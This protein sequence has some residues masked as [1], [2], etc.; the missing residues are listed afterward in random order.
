M[1]EN[2]SLTWI[3]GGKNIPNNLNM[4]VKMDNEDISVVTRHYTLNTSNYGPIVLAN[5]TVNS[6]EVEMKTHKFVLCVHKSRATAGNNCVDS[7]SVQ[8]FSDSPIQG[9]GLL[10]VYA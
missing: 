9:R 5:F 10:I 6:T 1:N 3:I 7:T 8:V 4:T 2:I